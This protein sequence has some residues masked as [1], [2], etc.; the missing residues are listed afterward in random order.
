[1]QYIRGLLYK[2]EVCIDFDFCSK[3]YAR[4][5]ILHADHPNHT[6]KEVGP[7]FEPEDDGTGSS[8]TSSTSDSD[9]DS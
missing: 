3:C 8:D 2:C 6:F 7:E 9:S 5:D 4:R 1:M